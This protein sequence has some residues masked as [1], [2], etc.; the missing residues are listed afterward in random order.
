MAQRPHDN[1]R[2]NDYFAREYL[3][4]AQYSMRNDPPGYG[5]AAGCN[6]SDDDGF[7]AV[8]SSSSPSGTSAVRLQ[9]VGYGNGSNYASRSSRKPSSRKRQPDCK[10][11]TLL[12]C[13]IA[14]LVGVL[15]GVLV[16]AG[17]SQLL[18]RAPMPSASVLTSQQLDDVVGTYRFKG[19][20]YSITARDAILGSV[21]LDSMAL[22]DGTYRA[23]SAD[24]ILACARN[25]ILVLMVEEAGVTVSSEEVAAY[26]RQ[27]VGSDDIATVAALYGME[28]DQ[29]REIMRQAA[30]VAKLRESVVTDSSTAPQPPQEPSD[31][32]AE[33]GNALYASYIIGLLGANWDASTNTWAN[34]DNEY[35]R[36][37]SDAVFSHDS[38]NYEAAQIAYNVALRLYEESRGGSDAWTDY[39]NGYLNEAA[40]SITTLRA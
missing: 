22:D 29:A 23:P 17:L 5:S 38:A 16:M 2:Y 1:R 9:P 10:S 18:P 39:V 31:G 24:M 26:A 19:K 30:A 11:H 25:E 33:V 20:T 27:T 8:L 4:N 12:L 21:S 40:I 35:Y 37:L 28:E 3:D 13:V 36:A 15:I 34:M 6:Y 7:D 14:C 32:N